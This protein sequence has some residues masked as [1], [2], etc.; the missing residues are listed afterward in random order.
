M[1]EAETKVFFIALGIMAGFS[2][3]GIWKLIE[4]AISVVQHFHFI[5]S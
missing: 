4:L 3:L 5:W 1:F 2:I